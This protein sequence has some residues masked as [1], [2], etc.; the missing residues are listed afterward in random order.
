MALV[1]ALAVLMRLFAE[2]RDH[3]M[4]TY[5]RAN[6]Y[7]VIS[8]EGAACEAGRP[9]SRSKGSPLLAATS[10]VARKDSASAL[11]LNVSP[12]RRPSTDQRTVWV[13]PRFPL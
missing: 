8:V 4:S 13:V 1:R 2:M 11:F 9:V 3:F 7:Q 6:S 10:R 12:C 5:W